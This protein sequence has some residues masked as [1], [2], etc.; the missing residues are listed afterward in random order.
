MCLDSDAN[1]LII[2]RLLK[3]IIQSE[4]AELAGSGTIARAFESGQCKLARL[5]IASIKPFHRF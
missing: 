2:Y 3:F 1:L 5:K 4:N